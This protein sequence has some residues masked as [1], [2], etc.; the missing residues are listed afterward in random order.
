MYKKLILTI[1]IIFLLLLPGGLTVHA[2]TT[3]GFETTN[4]SDNEKSEIWKNINI[5]SLSDSIS[6]NDIGSPIVSFDVS[7][8]ENILLGFKGNRVAVLDKNREVLNFFEFSNDGSFYVQWNGN[9]ILLLLVRG[10]IIVEITSTGQL[11]DIVKVEDSSIHNTSRWNNISKKVQVNIG[12][13][14]YSI[15]NK[16]GFLNIFSSSYSQLIKSD[17]NGNISTVYDVNS[18][19]LT[20]T[21]VIFIAIILFIAL[22]AVTVVRQFLKAKSQCSGFFVAHKKL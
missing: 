3:F 22:V 8:S 14:S 13:T 10:S 18:T 5:K 15:T 2:S 19:Q 9:N 11:I 17:S 4:L 1:C 21:I 16:M 7:E 20:K 12:G 6:L